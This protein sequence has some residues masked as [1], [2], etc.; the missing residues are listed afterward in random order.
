MGKNRKWALATKAK[1]HP[2]YNATCTKI[3]ERGKTSWEKPP[4]KIQCNQ[5]RR[6]RK[7]TVAKKS[8]PSLQ[9]DHAKSETSAQ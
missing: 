1:G 3:E 5:K 4:L 2:K 7:N 9:D 8:C 6:G